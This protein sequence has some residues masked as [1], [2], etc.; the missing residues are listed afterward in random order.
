MIHTP[1]KPSL[2]VRPSRSAHPSEFSLISQHSFG[3]PPPGSLVQLT[4]KHTLYFP[5][6]GTQMMPLLPLGMSNS[7]ST[8]QGPVKV[9]LLCKSFS[10]I[11]AGISLPSSQSIREL[12]HS[13]YHSGGI[14]HKLP[15][16]RTGGLGSYSNCALISCVTLGKDLPSL[17]L[18]FFI[19]KVGTTTVP[20]LM[21]PL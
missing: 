2:G 6:G 21:Q 8:L 14:C 13:L 15:C 16:I 4:F 5:T 12:R 20:T 3:S 1:L 19:H 11:F 10:I 18:S 7:N 9:Y 17:C